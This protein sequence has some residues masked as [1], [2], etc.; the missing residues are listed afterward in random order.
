MKSLLEDDLIYLG[1]LAL[2]LVSHRDHS[3]SSSQNIS[4]SLSFPWPIKEGF[5]DHVRR[6]QEEHP[7]AIGLKS[8]IEENL[9]ECVEKR[10]L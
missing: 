10:T 4:Y 5:M 6:D 8:G 3:L 7:Y 2:D 1:E 9:C